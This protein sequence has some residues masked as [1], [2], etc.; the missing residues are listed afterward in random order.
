[1]NIHTR[2]DDADKLALYLRES[3]FP[4]IEGASVE[5]FEL[6]MAAY[7]RGWARKNKKKTTRKRG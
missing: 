1:M 3:M 7:I 2:L 4:T 6:E 5:Q